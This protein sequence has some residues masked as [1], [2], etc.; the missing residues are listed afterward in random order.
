VNRVAAGCTAIVVIRDQ[1]DRVCSVKG[2]CMTL[3]FTGTLAMI[4]CGVAGCSSSSAPDYGPPSATTTIELAQTGG[5][6]A[7]N[8]RGV[9]IVGTVA[10]YTAADRT[11][12]A[13]IATADVAAMIDALEQ[14]DFLALHGNY[15]TCANPSTDLPNVTITVALAAG[16]NSVMHYLGCGG[17]TFDD[18]AA[19][20]E[21]IF[22]DSGFAAWVATR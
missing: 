20:D 7:S 4:L 11:D 3:S 14:V 12:Q 9:K 15:T 19:L 17:G 8:A 5:F 21:H 22:E 1:A 13:T 10:T 16:T 2:G 6:V 18:L